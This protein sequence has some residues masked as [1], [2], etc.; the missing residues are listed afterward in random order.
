MAIIITISSAMFLTANRM[1][2]EAQMANASMMIGTVSLR[3][4]LS[5][6]GAIQ[7]ARLSS[8]KSIP[9]ML[10]ARRKME[11]SWVG[12]SVLFTHQ[13]TC[14]P[15]AITPDMATAKDPRSRLREIHAREDWIQS[16]CR[17]LFLF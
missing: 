6:A 14:V 2:T 1:S 3:N 17:R 8:I 5:S 12:K 7:I 11:T 16:S 4:V 15:Q 9:T 13:T 10:G